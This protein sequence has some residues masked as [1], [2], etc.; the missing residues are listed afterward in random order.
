[1]CLVFSLDTWV[2]SQYRTGCLE[3]CLSRPP[4][5]CRHAWQDSEYSPQQRGVD[6]QHQGAEAHV[7]PLA[8]VVA[9]RDDR[10]DGQDHVEGHRDPEEVPVHVLQDQ[11]EPG[12]P[13]YF[14]CGSRTAQAA[15]ARQ[16]AR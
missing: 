9:E 8:L 13:V 7:A 4:T 16:K 1:M 6:Q 12:L 2:H 3:K 15:G 5:A 11:R 10:V 14:A